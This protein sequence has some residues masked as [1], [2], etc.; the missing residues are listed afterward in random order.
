MS[1]LAST[2]GI[3]SSWYLLKFS[4]LMHILVKFQP[5]ILILTA[6]NL[7]KGWESVEND[8]WN[9]EITTVSAQRKLYGLKHLVRCES[10]ANI[11]FGLMSGN[12]FWAP[13]WRWSNWKMHF[14]FNTGIKVLWRIIVSSS[15]F[16]IIIQTRFRHSIQGN[17][18]LQRSMSR[19]CTRVHNMMCMDRVVEQIES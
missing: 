4:L 2:D 7:W 5:D 18:S 19:Q 6:P 12:K 1:G 9:P 13:R 11:T 3:C 14:G 8:P 10:A 17:P 15:R 16:I